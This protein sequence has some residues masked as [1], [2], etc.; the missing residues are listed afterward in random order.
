MYVKDY[1]IIIGS[2]FKKYLLSYIAK[3]LLMYYKFEKNRFALKINILIGL[4]AQ[5]YTHT[6]GTP[7]L[8]I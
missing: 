6:T 1:M 7:I 4:N 8:R 5:I 3:L 2:E